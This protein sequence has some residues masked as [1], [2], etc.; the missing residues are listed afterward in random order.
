MC[1]EGLWLNGE[2]TNP[3]NSKKNLN[4]ESLTSG[5]A[6]ENFSGN[7]KKQIPAT[8]VTNNILSVKLFSWSKF[9]HHKKT[10]QKNNP[11]VK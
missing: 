11:L 7:I 5:F 10:K 1:K 4:E 6:E 9:L 8:M 3:R 2:S